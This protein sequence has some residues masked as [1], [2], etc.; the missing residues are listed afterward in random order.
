LRACRYGG[1]NGVN[2][3]PVDNEKAVTDFRQYVA[4]ASILRVNAD[5]LRFDTIA[6][7]EAS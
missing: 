5:G 7:S 4:L 1:L 6:V 3:S 2:A